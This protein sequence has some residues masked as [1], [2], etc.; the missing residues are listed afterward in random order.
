MQILVQYI[1]FYV[2]KFLLRAKKSV[3]YPNEC[4]IIKESL[5]FNF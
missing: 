2:L 5:Y 3:Q 1:S 4:Q